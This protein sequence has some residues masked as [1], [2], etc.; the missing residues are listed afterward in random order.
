MPHN[1]PFWFRNMAYRCWGLVA[2]VFVRRTVGARALVIKDQKI[3]LVKHTYMPKWY[4]IGGGVKLKESP[5]QGTIRELKEEAGITAQGTLELL[6]VYYKVHQG[7]D[8]YVVVYI[9]KDFKEEDYI[10]PHEIVEKRWFPLDKLPEDISPG[11][12]RR[13]QEYLKLKPVSDQW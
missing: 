12:L 7:H 9:C 11:C 2:W 10:C 3:L 5:L 8:D 13:I 1:L 6:G 4:T